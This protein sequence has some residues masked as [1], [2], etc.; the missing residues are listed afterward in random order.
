M[1]VTC[2]SVQKFQKCLCSICVKKQNTPFLSYKAIWLMKP[3]KSSD[4][5]LLVQIMQERVAGGKNHYWFVCKCFDTD[6][7]HTSTIIKMLTF[8]VKKLSRGQVRPY[9]PFCSSGNISINCFWQIMVQRMLFL[10]KLEHKVHTFYLNCCKT[11]WD[12]NK[13]NA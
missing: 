10:T 3:M 7:S 5:L 13:A 8:V 6:N 1:L 11:T 9:L 4:N 2:C 12:R